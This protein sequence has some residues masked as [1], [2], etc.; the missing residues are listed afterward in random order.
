MELNKV[1]AA[2]LVAGILVM[3]SGMISNYLVHPVELEEP[4]YFVDT[5]LVAVEVG[6]GDEIERIPSIIPLMAN[7]D[8]DAGQ[9]LTRA[10]TTCHTFDQGGA[11][12]VGPN[13]WDIVGQDVAHIEGFGYSQTLEAMHETGVTWTYENLNRFLY[14]PRE[15]AA[16]TTMAYAGMRN[17][18]DRADLIAWLRLQSDDPFPLPDAEAVAQA[19]GA[20]APM[21]ETGPATIPEPEGELAEDAAATAL[22]E[23]ADDGLDQEE[24][25]DATEATEIERQPSEPDSDSPQDDG[26]ADAN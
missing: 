6:G 24:A 10:C 17:I 13:N 14:Q 4:A 5:G 1:F 20:T 22:E 8:P 16:G 25:N 15:W 3:L 19:T 11:N 26:A 23:A 21:N 18:E 9:A 12:G 7:A 2:V